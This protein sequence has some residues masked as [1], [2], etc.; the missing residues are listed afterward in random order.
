[1]HACFNLIYSCA[2][3]KKTGSGKEDAEKEYT[4]EEEKQSKHINAHPPDSK[5]E[6]LH[7][8]KLTELCEYNHLRSRSHHT[9]GSSF[10]FKCIVPTER[11]SCGFLTC[12]VHSVISEM[13][14]EGSNEKLG[15]LEVTP[16]SRAI[17]R[18]MCVDLSPECLPTRSHKGIAIIVYGAPQTGENS[19]LSIWKS[20][21]KSCWL[22]IYIRTC[23]MCNC[24]YILFLRFL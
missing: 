8:M 4:Q 6:E 12:F 23:C 16:V 17:A 18:H 22:D 1:M 14:R 11:L 9:Y 21:M 20:E 13:T 5:Q 24:V 3:V 10:N 7:T 19:S 15:Q 2:P